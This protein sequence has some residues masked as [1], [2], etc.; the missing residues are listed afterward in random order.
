MERTVIFNKLTDIYREVFE[1]ERLIIS[2]ETKAE[3]VEGWDSL[4]HFSLISEIETAFGI[5]FTLGEIQG[6]KNVRELVDA[7]LGHVEGKNL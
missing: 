3:D 4:T 6:C 7:L 5:R 1:D 2:E